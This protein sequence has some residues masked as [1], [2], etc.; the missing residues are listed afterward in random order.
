MCEQRDLNQA[1]I[2]RSRPNRFKITAQAIHG[3]NII[4]QN[5]I[6]SSVPVSPQGNIT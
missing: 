6:H 4:S 2:F 5:N 1:P 3:L